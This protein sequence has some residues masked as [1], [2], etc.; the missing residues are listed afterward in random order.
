MNLP[1]YLWKSLIKMATRVK[2]HPKDI[3]TSLFHHSLIKLLVEG[4]VRKRNQTWE[5][6]MFWFGLEANP[7]APNLTSTSQSKKARSTPLRKRKIPTKEIKGSGKSPQTIP[8][9]NLGSTKHKSNKKISMNTGE[10]IN[11]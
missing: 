2:T 6:F 7:L 9:N 5:Q 11:S 3:N 8:I 1:F 10:R 4:E